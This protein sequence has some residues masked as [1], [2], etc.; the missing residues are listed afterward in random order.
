MWN[1]TK[2]P[3]SPPQGKQDPTIYKIITRV[4]VYNFIIFTDPTLLSG[5][6]LSR[7]EFELMKQVPWGGCPVL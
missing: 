7:E 2:L 5:P 6:V 3:R 1:Q 4:Y